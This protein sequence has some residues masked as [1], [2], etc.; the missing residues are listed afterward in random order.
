MQLRGT[1]PLSLAEVE[2]FGTPRAPYTAMEIWR[3]QHFGSYDNS[4]VAADDY[5]ADFDGIVNLIEYATGL[6]PNVS[7]A[8][9]PIEMRWNAGETEL[10]VVFNRIDD[11]LLNYVLQSTDDLSSTDWDPVWSGTGTAN[12]SVSVPESAWPSGQPSYFFRLKISR[13]E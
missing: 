3:H 8:T 12:E 13:D 1:D 7:Q 11:S 10:E 2:I 9:R 4:G 6:D 5:D